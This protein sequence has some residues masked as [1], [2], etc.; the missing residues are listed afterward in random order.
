MKSIYAGPPDIYVKVSSGDSKNRLND[1]LYWMITSSH[2]SLI[3]LVR[4]VDIN[5]NEI[6]TSATSQDGKT[7]GISISFAAGGLQAGISWTIV[8]VLVLHTKMS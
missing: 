2:C 4:D 5:I 8:H 6:I 3:F 7:L 1:R